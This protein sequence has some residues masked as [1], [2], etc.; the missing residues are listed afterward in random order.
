MAR[1]VII[2]ALLLLGACSNKPDRCATVFTFDPDGNPA[3]CEICEEPGRMTMDCVIKDIEEA[4]YEQDSR[5]VYQ[6]RL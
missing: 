5:T 1:G 3:K 6:T 2:A 4:L